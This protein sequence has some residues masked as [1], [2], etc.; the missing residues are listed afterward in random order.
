[1]ELLCA[2]C[3]PDNLSMH[4]LIRKPLHSPY[5]LEFVT[6]DILSAES[7][8]WNQWGGEES[9]IVLHSPCK[10]PFEHTALYIQFRSPEPA[11]IMIMV[12]LPLTFCSLI[13]QNLIDLSH[14]ARVLLRIRACEG[15]YFISRQFNHVGVLPRFRTY[16]RQAPW[17]FYC[18]STS[19]YSASSFMNSE[20]NNYSDPSLNFSLC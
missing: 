8:D 17:S 1:M 19:I 18:R 13:N 7:A 5:R 9:R 10:S 14:S 16:C 20:Q 11:K 3:R 6:Y 2:G 4:H 15:R 12:L